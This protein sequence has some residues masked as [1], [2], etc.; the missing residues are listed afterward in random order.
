M[1][2][3]NKEDKEDNNNIRNKKMRSQYVFNSSCVRDQGTD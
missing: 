3:N 2:S 1:I